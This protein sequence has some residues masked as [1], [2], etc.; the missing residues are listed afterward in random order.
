MDK[1]QLSERQRNDRGCCQCGD[2]YLQRIRAI[3][4]SRT[5]SRYCHSTH[6]RIRSY[7]LLHTTLLHTTLLHTQPVRTGGHI[8]QQTRF[9]QNIVRRSA[10]CIIVARYGLYGRILVTAMASPLF[11]QCYGIQVGITPPVCSMCQLLSRDRSTPTSSSSSTLISSRAS[12]TL[13]SLLAAFCHHSISSPAATSFP[14]LLLFSPSECHCSR[15]LEVE[16][17]RRRRNWARRGMRWRQKKG[18]RRL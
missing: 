2:T 14:P 18:L 13:P 10:R 1:Q 9:E 11:V 7:H 3:E 15:L 5:T 12:S 4:G 17:G 6:S 8:L 16:A